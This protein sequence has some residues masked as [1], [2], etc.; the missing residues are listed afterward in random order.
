MKR[1]SNHGLS[2]RTL[3]GGAGLGVAALIGAPGRRPPRPGL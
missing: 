3:L 1:T 2:R